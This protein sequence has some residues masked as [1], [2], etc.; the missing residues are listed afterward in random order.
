MQL[1]RIEKGLRTQIA[2]LEA[3]NFV[4]KEKLNELNKKYKFNLDKIKDL[5]SK[6][7]N[8]KSLT[9]TE[10]AVLRYLERVE[11]INIEEIEKNI[12]SAQ[13]L[14]CHSTLGNGRFPIKDN[15]FA[16]IKNNKIVTIET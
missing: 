8:D 3:E 12:F 14:K 16:V 5:K 4:L 6:I 13:L 15:V 1:N 7:N 2:D 11:K 10:H 9:L